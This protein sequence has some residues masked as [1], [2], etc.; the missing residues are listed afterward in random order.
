M[1]KYFESNV[2]MQFNWE[3]VCSS[4]RTLYLIIFW[5]P[6]REN[7]WKQIWKIVPSLLCSNVFV[8]EVRKT[9]HVQQVLPASMLAIII[10]AKALII[11]YS[12]SLFVFCVLQS[13]F[14]W[15][16]LLDSSTA[17]VNV[18]RQEVFEP[19]DLRVG[20]PAGG[21]EHGSSARSLHHLQLRAHVYGGEAV[22]DLVLWKTHTTQPQRERHQH[23]WLNCMIS[24]YKCSSA[25]PPG[26]IG[27]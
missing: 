9:I 15:T 23:T 4:L 2:A 27:P 20:V 10:F 3:L 26:V 24:S 11:V 13:F 21:T 1:F 14:T 17:A 8:T 7:E 22:R 18:D 12:S 16:E 19:G 5:N 25:G 6:Y